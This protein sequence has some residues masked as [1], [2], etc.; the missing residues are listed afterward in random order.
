[1]AFRIPN[2]VWLWLAV[3]KK[4]YLLIFR[5]CLNSFIEAAV[6]NS[7]SATRITSTNVTTTPPTATTNEAAVEA[8]STDQSMIPIV[9]VGTSSTSASTTTTLNQNVHRQPSG[10][11]TTTR[12]TISNQMTPS[13][14]ESNII[15]EEDLLLYNSYGSLQGSFNLEDEDDPQ[16]L[17]Q[18]LL[19][20][21]SFDC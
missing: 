13:M 16:Q 4:V 20:S 15:N 17:D 21:V 11:T 6:R 2:L 8:I 3:V 5:I 12:T 19:A 10:T 9:V 7:N 14:N 18:G 1:M